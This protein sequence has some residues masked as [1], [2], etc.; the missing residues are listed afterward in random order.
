MK[1]ITDGEFTQLAKYIK[2]HTGINLKPEK[3]TLLIGRLTSLL[4]ELNMQSFGDFYDHLVKDNDGALL[5][6][7]IDRITTNHTYFMREKEHFDYLVDQVFPYLQTSVHN[8]DLRIWCAAS[9]TGEEPYTLAMLLEDYF[10]KSIV[11]WDKKLLAT[12]ISLDVLSKAKEGFYIKEKVDAVPKLWR[13]NYFERFEEGYKIKPN[14][15][16]QVIYRRF[17]LLEP[18]F[19]FKGKFHVIFCRNVLI[20][21]DGP[22][23]KAVIEKMYNALEYGGYLFIG[24]SESIDRNHSKFKYVK[25]AVYRKV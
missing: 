17:N 8:R 14:I 2:S 24:H 15:R 4:D 13:L 5:S 19:P 16:N 6:R 9:S 22:T 18:R 21:F 11:K 7:V 10:G 20:Y 1:K 12:D 23:K 3:K 25:P